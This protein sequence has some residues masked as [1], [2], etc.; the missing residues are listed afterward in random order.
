MT[1][2]NSYLHPRVFIDHE[3]LLHEVKGSINFNGSN[4]L[5]S[6]NI[7][8]GNIDIQ[9]SALFNKLITLYLNNGSDD[10]VPIFRGYINS[11]KPSTTSINVTA[12]DVRTVLNSKSGALINLTDRD[13]YD[14]NTLAQFIYQYVTDNINTN[15][16]VIGL[17][18]L[19]DTNPPVFVTN[20]RLD[21]DVYSVITNTIKDAINEDD[22]LNPL[23][24]FI[25]VYEGANHSNI[26]LV[27]EKLISS[28]PSY[29]FSYDDG[30]KS[31]S[32]NRRIPANTAFYKGGSF[33]YTN[34]PTGVVGVK[35]KDAGDTAL[36]RNNAIRDILINQQEKD[37]ITINVTKGY[38]IGLGSIIY[39]DVDEDDINGNHR[40]Q[41]KTISFGDTISCSLKLNKKPIKMSD[42]ISSK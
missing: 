30:L 16:T 22:F 2:E 21:S 10:S 12:L 24:H 17:D 38:D 29:S 28:T 32:Y 31:C 25:D 35:V 37:E 41:G 26:T 4:K 19:R 14:G 39:L 20:Q 36:N 27:K 7:T 8:I 6:L 1:Q 9:Y 11:V 13:N 5:N 33:K 23:T 15:K 42:Y 34:Q 3:E 18:M 40:V